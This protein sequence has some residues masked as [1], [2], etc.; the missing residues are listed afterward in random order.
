MTAFFINSQLKVVA[1]F[2]DH[3]QGI[4]AFGKLYGFTDRMIFWSR[5]G[6]EDRVMVL[7][8]KGHFE[9]IKIMPEMYARIAQ[10]IMVFCKA[11]K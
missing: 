3:A 5:L 6:Y 7:D 4:S 10:G 9:E 2:A 11:G 1:A 8:E